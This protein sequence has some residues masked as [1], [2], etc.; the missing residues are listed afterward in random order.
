M[1]I[2]IDTY[3]DEEQL[4]IDNSVLASLCMSRLI[5]EAKGLGVSASAGGVSAQRG[6]GLRRRRREHDRRREPRQC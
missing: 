3:E 6:R 1:V 2:R 5:L 4:V